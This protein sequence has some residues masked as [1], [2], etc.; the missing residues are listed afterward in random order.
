MVY[1]NFILFLPLVSCSFYLVFETVIFMRS[2]MYIILRTLNLVKHLS[3]N[4][5]AAIF[6]QY[7]HLKPAIVSPL[8]Q[9]TVHISENQ[10][11]CSYYNV[12]QL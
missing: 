9:N 3:N 1:F 12:I 6:I 2:E 10:Y 4:A 7:I 8:Q 11:F 5:M